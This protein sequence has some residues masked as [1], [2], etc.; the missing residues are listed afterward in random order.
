MKK[1]P[2]G[3]IGGGASRFPLNAG[4]YCGGRIGC[5]RGKYCTR[6]VPSVHSGWILEVWPIL[7]LRS[8]LMFGWWFFT[9]WVVMKM[10]KLNLLYDHDLGRFSFVERG[11]GGVAIVLVREPKAITTESFEIGWV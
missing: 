5:L 9:L 8:L 7:I 3:E 1:L 2:E 4:G 10:L 6:E 11:V